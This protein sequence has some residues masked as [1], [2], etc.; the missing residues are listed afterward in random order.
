MLD[1]ENSTGAVNTTAA[2]Q[3]NNVFEYFVKQSVIQN[4]KW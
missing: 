1:N 2:G 3:N 4:K